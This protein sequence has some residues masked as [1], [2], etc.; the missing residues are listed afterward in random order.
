MAVRLPPT[1]LALLLALTLAAGC[2]GVDSLSADAPKLS[3]AERDDV[4]AQVEKAIEQQR[5]NLAWN[6]EV[7]AGAD[8]ERL[9]RVAVEALR[10]RSRHAPSMFTELR[11]RHGGLSADA[12]TK[13]T[14]QTDAAKQEGLWSRAVQIELMTADDPPAYA[15]AWAVYR[16]APPD[17]APDLL[18]AITDAKAAHAESAD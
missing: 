1:A 14:L 5:F 11:E 10:A 2:S 12:R 8:R 17:Q 9:E 7:Q 13:V 16:A 15:G 3:D 18:A 4:R 6:Q